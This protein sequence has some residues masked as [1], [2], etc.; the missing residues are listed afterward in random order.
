MENNSNN[1]KN[2]IQKKEEKM[3]IGKKE[4]QKNESVDFTKLK[5]RTERDKQLK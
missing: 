2:K 5:L 3:K 1:G 4:L